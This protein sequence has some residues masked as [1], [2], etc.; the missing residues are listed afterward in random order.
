LCPAPYLLT[1][2]LINKTP[3]DATGWDTA[4]TRRSASVQTEIHKRLLFDLQTRR[5][6]CT[7]YPAA[8]AAAMPAAAAI[9]GSN[10]L[11]DVNFLTAVPSTAE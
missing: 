10:Y 2:L 3:G 4:V 1:Y 11:M 5:C 8:A 7:R 6:G 9:S